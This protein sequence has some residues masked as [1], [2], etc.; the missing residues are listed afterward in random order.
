MC[1]FVPHSALGP[2]TG[3]VLVELHEYFH[4]AL[5]IRGNRRWLAG[6]VCYGRFDGRVMEYRLL[7]RLTRLAYL[8]WAET[9]WD[10]EM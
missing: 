8:Q 2:G 10:W 4:Q 3:L 9:P 1:S 6:P 7:T 5:V